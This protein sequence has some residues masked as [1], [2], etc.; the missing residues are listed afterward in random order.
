VNRSVVTQTDE[1]RRVDPRWPLRRDD[2]PDQRVLEQTVTTRCVECPSCF[3]GTLAD[4]R[5]WHLGHRRIHAGG[6]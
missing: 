3:T 2:Q 5:A 1:K 4:G 6:V